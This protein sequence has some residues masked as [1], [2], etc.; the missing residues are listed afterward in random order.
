MVTTMYVYADFINYSSGVYKHTTGSGL[1]GHAVSLIGFDDVKRAWII[2]NSWGPDWGMSGFG[3]VSYD[4]VS[5]ISDD[6]EQFQID[7]KADYLVTSFLDRSFLSGTADIRVEGKAKSAGTMVL[8]VNGN[9]RKITEATCDGS[10][11]TLHLDTSTLADGT[12]TFEAHKGDASLYRYF[13][14]ANQAPQFQIKMTAQDFDPSQIV[15][16]RIV[17]GVNIQSATS[18]PLKR[19]ALVYENANGELKERWADILVNDMTIGWRTPMVA[20]GEYTLW[21]RGEAYNNG[22]TVIVDSNKVKI[23]IQN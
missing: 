16:D 8:K 10:D 20:N 11:C 2:R 5:G 17:V 19:I 18:V 1:G 21:V 14:V 7:E 9:G 15:R 13:Y 6:N 12:Y 3:Y 23:N 22:Q 4:D